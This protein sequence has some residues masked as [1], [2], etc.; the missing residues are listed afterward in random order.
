MGQIRDLQ[1]PVCLCAGK[2]AEF[3]MVSLSSGALVHAAGSSMLQQSLGACQEQGCC[4]TASRKGQWHDKACLAQCSSQTRGVAR[5]EFSLYD[6]RFEGLLPGTSAL[7]LPL[8]QCW[9]QSIV[10]LL[11]LCYLSNEGLSDRENGRGTCSPYLIQ[12]L[13]RNGCSSVGCAK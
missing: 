6:R 4:C 12:H 10:C 2:H 1:E 8:Y 11:L 7:L 9:L 5:V 13:L 3:G